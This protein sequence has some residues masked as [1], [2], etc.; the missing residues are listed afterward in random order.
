M[1]SHTSLKGLSSAVQKLSLTETDN[2]TALN[3][4]QKTLQDIRLAQNSLEKEL[5]EQE[6][7]QDWTQAKK[8]LIQKDE[9]LKRIL[10]MPRSEMKKMISL[11]QE[12]D[13]LERKIR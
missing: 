2:R 4:E 12:K 6:G 5:A 13:K 9:E 10:D 7:S 3:G 8:E 11:R 1:N